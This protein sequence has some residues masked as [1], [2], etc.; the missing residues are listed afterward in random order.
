MQPILADCKP[1]SPPIAHDIRAGE[2]EERGEGKERK[3]VPPPSMKGTCLLHIVLITS[4]RLLTVRNTTPLNTLARNPL[5]QCLQDTV[6]T[7]VVPNNPPSFSNP[8]FNIQKN[9]PTSAH[10]GFVHGLSSLS[11]LLAFFRS[12]K[13]ESLQISYLFF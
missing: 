4:I 8:C 2:G 3:N 13:I 12:P 10:S 9:P 1:P 5:I 7:A 6:P 11:L